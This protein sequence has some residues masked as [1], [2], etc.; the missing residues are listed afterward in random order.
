MLRQNPANHV[1][2]DTCAEGQIDLIGDTQAAPSRIALFHLDNGASDLRIW[3]LW[4]GLGS[5][6]SVKTAADTFAGPG[7]DGSLGWWRA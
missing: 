6:A 4:S 1:L 5:P 7:P 2:I 3:S